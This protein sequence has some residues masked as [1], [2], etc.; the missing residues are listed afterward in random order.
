MSLAKMK[1]HINFEVDSRCS[2]I[3]GASSPGPSPRQRLFV[4]VIFV[5]GLAKTKL[6]TNFKSLASAIIEMSKGKPQ[7]SESSLAQGHAHFC[8]LV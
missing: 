2:P 8:L 5:I 3:L 1:R 7:I 4:D 6:H